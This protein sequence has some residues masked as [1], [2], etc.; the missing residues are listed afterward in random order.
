MKTPSTKQTR[1]LTRQ[2]AFLRGINVGGHKPVKMEALAGWFADLGFKNV[3][4]VLASGNVLF[5]AGKADAEVLIN[6]IENKLKAELGHSVD[7][8]V[9]SVEELE[10]LSN[11]NPFKAIKVTTQTRLYVTFLSK[12][13]QSRLK[14]PHTS[15]DKAFQIIRLSEREVFSVATL[16]PQTQTTDLMKILEREFGKKVTTRNWNTIGRILK[17]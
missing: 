9:R 3:K 12:K 8:I 7:V 15:P 17:S 1:S 11:P 16:S 4:T 14:I 13:P 5:D 2:V 10:S 6:K